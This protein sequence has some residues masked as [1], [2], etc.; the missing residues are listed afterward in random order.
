MH[1]DSREV[2]TMTTDRRGIPSTR[3]ICLDEEAERWATESFEKYADECCDGRE[4]PA[5]E[6]SD[7]EALTDMTEKDEG[8]HQRR[9]RGRSLRFAIASVIGHPPTDAEVMRFYG[10]DARE[11]LERLE[12]RGLDRRA[13]VSGVKVRAP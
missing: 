3:G 10:G 12:K 11:S 5:G 1:A 2:I 13:F 7:A 6:G 4:G 8:G 9:I